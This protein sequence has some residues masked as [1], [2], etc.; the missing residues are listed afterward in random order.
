MDFNHLHSRS[1]L[2]MVYSVFFAFMLFVSGCR[3]VSKPTYSSH[4]ISLKF[5]S[6]IQDSQRIFIQER[7][8]I[9]MF[10]N[11]FDDDLMES[12]NRKQEYYNLTD[13]QG[14]FSQV[15]EPVIDS[16]GVSAYSL[17]QFK[18]T[19][20]FTGLQGKKYMVKTNTLPCSQGLII[21]NGHQEPVFW[22]GDESGD[23]EDFLRYYFSNK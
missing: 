7:V 17:S 6:E 13:F 5:E 1:F 22:K 8:I 23:L 3:E 20:V 21:F 18:G 19:I 4:L 2:W 9:K 15:V 14:Y 10:V 12:Q 11:E 16:M